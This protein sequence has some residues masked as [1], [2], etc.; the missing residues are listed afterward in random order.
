[1]SVRSDGLVPL[2]VA[3]GIHDRLQQVRNKS[4]RHRARRTGVKVRQQGDRLLTVERA[5]DRG[6]TRPD[7]GPKLR[8]SLR[9]LDLEVGDLVDLLRQTDQERHA[10]LYTRQRCILNHDRQTRLR[11]LGELLARLL[12]GSLEGRSVVR[13][14][15]HHHGRPEF[16]RSPAAFHDDPGRIV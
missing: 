5:L 6:A 3:V 7:Q 13:R 15:Q 2:A 4:A 11:R 9:C 14:H 10:E 1:M 12:L 8:R 16:R